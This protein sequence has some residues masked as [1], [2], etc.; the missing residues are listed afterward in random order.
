MRSEALAQTLIRNKQ[1][2]LDVLTMREED[3]PEAMGK[4]LAV[5]FDAGYD[6]GYDQGWPE[7]YNAGYDNGSR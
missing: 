1:R 5:V 6:A 4:L 7:G 2:I 3:Q